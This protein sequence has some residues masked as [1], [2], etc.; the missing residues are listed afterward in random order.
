[1]LISL[2]LPSICVAV[3][4]V[5][6]LP[7]STPPNWMAIVASRAILRAIASDIQLGCILLV[8]LEIAEAHLRNFLARVIGAPIV[9]VPTELPVGSAV[10]GVLSLQSREAGKAIGGIRAVYQ[11]EILAGDAVPDKRRLILYALIANRILR[12]EL[13][14]ERDWLPMLDYQVFLEELNSERLRVRLE[15]EWNADE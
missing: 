8:R 13:A 1:M 6:T 3:P 14:S 2:H 10:A 15:V 7:S 9:S 5:I 11:L 4:Q 12:T